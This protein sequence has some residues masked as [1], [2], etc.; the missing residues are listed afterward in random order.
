MRGFGFVLFKDRF[1]YSRVFDYG[2]THM[3]KG[4]QVPDR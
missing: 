3:I 4:K 2:E 1:S